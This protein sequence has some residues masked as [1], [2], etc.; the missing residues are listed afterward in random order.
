MASLHINCTTDGLAD[1][2]PDF[3]ARCLCDHYAAMYPDCNVSVDMVHALRSTL[4]YSNDDVED[5]QRI[6]E[7]LADRLQDNINL[8]FDKVCR[9]EYGEFPGII[10]QSSCR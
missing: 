5:D 7:E 3:F 1:I 6:A 8:V 9:G 2:Q 10:W 4:V